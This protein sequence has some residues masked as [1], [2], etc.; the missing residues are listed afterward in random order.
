MKN[1]RIH[2]CH[3]DNVLRNDVFSNI[4]NDKLTNSFAENIFESGRSP[5]FHKL[6]FWKYIHLSEIPRSSTRGFWKYVQTQE[7]PILSHLRFLLTPGAAGG[8][9]SSLISSPERATYVKVYSAPSELIARDY[10]VPPVSPWVIHHWLFQ[11]Q[12]SESTLLIYRY[13]RVLGG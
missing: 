1:K 5:F 7:I 10:H 9:A 8:I 4:S 13:L 3:I 2:I 11:S 12:P 6:V